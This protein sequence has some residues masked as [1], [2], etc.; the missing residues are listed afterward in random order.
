MIVAKR[1]CEGK[2]GREGGEDW[3]LRV[4]ER[5]SGRKLRIDRG[6]SR[7]QNRG[8]GFLKGA[9]KSEMT[10]ESP[11]FEESLAELSAIVGELDEGNLPL[12][13]TLQRYERAMELIKVCTTLLETAEQRVQV[14]TGGNGEEPKQKR[15]EGESKGSGGKRKKGAK[16]DDGES[17][18]GQ[19]F[20]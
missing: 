14:V 2:D 4:D 11:R 17:S 6:K 16:T 9:G 1:E 18:G 5:E 13:A 10:E 20:E 12:E 8:G 19:L 3:N 15:A 7:N